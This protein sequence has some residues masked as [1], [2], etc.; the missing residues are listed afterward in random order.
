MFFC[1]GPMVICACGLLPN[2]AKVPNF[3]Y[4]AWLL[5]MFFGSEISWWWWKTREP[6]FWDLVQWSTAIIQPK[7]RNSNKRYDGILSIGKSAPYFRGN[8]QFPIYYFL[9]GCHLWH[10]FPQISIQ[11]TEFHLLFPLLNFTI[12]FTTLQLGWKWFFFTIYQFIFINFAFQY[13]FSFKDFQIN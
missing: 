7:S 4:R 3:Q 9:L 11:N 8:T 13:N 1:I 12:C 2:P 5:I 6:Q 10:L